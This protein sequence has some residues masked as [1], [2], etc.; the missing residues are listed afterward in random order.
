MAS[1]N[2]K[3]NNRLPLKCR[4]REEREFQ[5]FLQADLEVV[6]IDWNNCE[7]ECPQK[8]QQGKYQ[9]MENIPA[10]DDT[11]NHVEECE[12]RVYDL[13]SAPPHSSFAATA[14]DDEFN[15]SRLKRRKKCRKVSTTRVCS[16]YF[17]HVEWTSENSSKSNELFDLF[18]IKT[19]LKISYNPK[20]HEIRT[21]FK[22]RWRFE[23]LRNLNCTIDHNHNH[24]C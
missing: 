9:K 14:E 24:N 1:K 10:D 6:E 3:A 16:Y 11:K 2:S 15:S 13:A 22:T 5:M 8:Q 18:R 12:K 21:N 17:E 23:E 4:P 20:N 7:G 19:F